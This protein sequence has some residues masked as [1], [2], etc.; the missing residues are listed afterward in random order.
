M[1]CLCVVVVSFFTLSDS[2]KLHMQP[3]ASSR[4]SLFGIV[5]S[6]GGAPPPSLP[7]VV[8]GCCLVTMTTTVRHSQLSKRQ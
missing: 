3:S 8:C 2:S 7:G 4:W 1:E 6:A 5:V